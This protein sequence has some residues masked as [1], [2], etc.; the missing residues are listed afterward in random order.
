MKSCVKAK[1]VKRVVLTSS[2]A[3]VTVN[4]LS[5]TG[6]IADEND[7]SDVEFLTTAKPPTWVITKL[8][9]FQEYLTCVI[10]ARQ[11]AYIE[12]NEPGDKGFFSLK[13]AGISCFK[14]T[15]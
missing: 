15:S 6:L 13:F 9:Q 8:F 12:I 10:D 1:T 4:T 14:G 5:G 7:W 3:A 11:K 2:A